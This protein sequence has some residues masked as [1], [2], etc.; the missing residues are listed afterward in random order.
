VRM[1]GS[2]SCHTIVQCVN[3][4]GPPSISLPLPPFLTIEDGT[5]TISIPR[6]PPPPPTLYDRMA[7]YA[8]DHPHVVDCFVCNAHVAALVINMLPHASSAYRLLLSAYQASRIYETASLE[9][10]LER[11]HGTC[12]RAPGVQRNS[13]CLMMV[14]AAMLEGFA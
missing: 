5:K 2:V 13:R 6:S 11:Y 1:V 7:G 14:N 9:G 8:S 3:A 4:F 10:S 12:F